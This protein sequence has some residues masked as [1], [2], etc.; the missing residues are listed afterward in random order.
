MK[1]LAVANLGLIITERC[2]LNCAHCLMGGCTNKIKSDEV[3][4]VTLSQ[5][6][7]IMNLSICGGN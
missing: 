5:F 6:N 3:I 7:Y 2:N 1:K 4:E